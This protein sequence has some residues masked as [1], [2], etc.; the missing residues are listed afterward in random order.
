MTTQLM[1]FVGRLLDPCNSP[2]AEPLFIQV[3]VV[4][5]CYRLAGRPAADAESLPNRV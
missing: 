4:I 2:R 5:L 1:H 3:P